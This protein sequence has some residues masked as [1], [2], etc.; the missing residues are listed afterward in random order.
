MKAPETSRTTLAVSPDDLALLRAEARRRGMSLAAL[1][2][3]IVAAEAEALRRSRR[4]RFG[5]GASATGAAREAAAH[6]EAPYEATGM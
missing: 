3:E 5:I 2:R 6:P 1:L 4:P